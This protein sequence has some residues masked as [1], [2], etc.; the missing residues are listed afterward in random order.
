MCLSHL[1]ES[2]VPS[3]LCGYTVRTNIHS[4][5]Y[6]YYILHTFPAGRGYFLSLRALD[7]HKACAPSGIANTNFAVS[8]LLAALRG[9]PD[10]EMHF[11]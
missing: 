6:V 4:M 1:R 2:H 10:P 3:R 9:Q 5:K 7:P 8:D 11:V